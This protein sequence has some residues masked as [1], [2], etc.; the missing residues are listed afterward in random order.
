MITTLIKPHITEKSL[1]ATG[2]NC[3]TFE[4]ALKATKTEI[5]A[6]VEAAFKVNVVDI[7]T[8]RTYASKKR[9]PRTGH[10]STKTATKYA[11]VKLAPK[12]TINLFE[13]K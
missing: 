1:I 7:H 2:R 10:Y 13:V 3:Y 12:Q 11:V 8:T 6:A 4:V 5:R 9:N